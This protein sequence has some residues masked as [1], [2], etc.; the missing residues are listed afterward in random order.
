LDISFIDDPVKYIPKYLKVINKA[1][2]LVPFNLLPAQKHYIE[3]RSHRD[4]I[5]KGRQM[6][7]STGV[8]AANAHILFTRPYQ[9][10][11]VITHDTETSEF[12]LQNINRFHRN[13]PPEVQPELDWSSACRMRFP[14]LD[15]YIYIDSAKSDAVGIGHTLNV[16]HASEL[17]RW[18]D[19]RARQLWADMTQTVPLE[20]YVTGESTPRG[21]VGLFYELWN[22]A[23]HNDI[24]YKTFFYPWWW[25]PAYALP[26]DAPLKLTKEEQ[27]M[28]DSYR[29]THPQ[30]AFRRL[31]QSELK[32]LFYQEYPEN[33]DQCWLTNDMGVV[34]PIVLQPYYLNVR[35]GVVEGPLTTWK[36]PVGGRRYVMGVDVA[37]GYARG[38]FSVASVIDVRTMEYV[39]RLRGRIPP[40]LFAEQAFNLAR[41]YNDATVAIEKT[42]H[43]HTVLRVFL[44]KNYSNLYYY[45]EYD[46]MQASNV[47]EPGWK[48]NTRTKPMMVNDLVAAFRSQDLLSWSANLLA[49]ASGLVWDGD[50]KVRKSSSNVWDDEWDAVSI[51][52][53]IREQTPIFSDERAP[54]AHY[55]R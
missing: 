34:D 16:A 4:L 3:N 33:E 54:V 55:G 44:E 46:N 20:G 42:G 26:L 2:V 36:G 37:G 9:R 29:L 50:K 27:L 41:K 23:R 8:E 6:G 32:E 31:K 45:V 17:A 53:Q 5:L 51:A 12:L 24:P 25:E 43:G 35:E 1:G 40:D 10:M 49:E 18:P 11:A 22:A 15:N 48:T 21:R 38:D 14:K 19:R 30:I 39:A 28:V 13:L 47:S 7:I 52:L